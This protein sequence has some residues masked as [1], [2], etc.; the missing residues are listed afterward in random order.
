MLHG[1][2]GLNHSSGNLG[3]R[4][5]GEFQLA[6]LAIIHREPLHQ[7]GGE[8]RAGTTTKGVEKEEALESRALISQLTNTVQ[9]QVNNFLANCVV[10]TG[11]V[12]SSIFLF[13]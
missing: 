13:S 8:T 10:A 5:D 6:L 11:I 9:N 12:V 1:I 4:V 3:S 2:V 7:K